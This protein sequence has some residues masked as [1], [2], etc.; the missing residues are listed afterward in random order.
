MSVWSSD[1]DAMI[2][3]GRR[4]V[5]CKQH[6]NWRIGMAGLPVSKESRIFLPTCELPVQGSAHNAIRLVSNV[7][8][9]AQYAFSGDIEVVRAHE[10]AYAVMLTDLGGEPV[11]D[12]SDYWLTGRVYLKDFIPDFFDSVTVDCLLRMVRDAW[13]A[14]TLNAVYSEYANGSCVW[15][16]HLPMMAHT[17]EGHTMRTLLLI[18]SDTE[19]GVLV[20]ALENAAI[21]AVN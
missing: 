10:Q 20:A 16:L 9:E 7:F 1:V 13:Q 14:P 6:W 11:E 12:I 21:A 17:G 15:S 5:A 4:A 19:I 18:E 8:N 2:E 3:L